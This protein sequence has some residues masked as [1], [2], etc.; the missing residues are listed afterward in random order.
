MRARPEEELEGI[1]VMRAVTRPLSEVAEP[2]FL[3]RQA[4]GDAYDSVTG[5]MPGDGRV[6]SHGHPIRVVV[7]TEQV[8]EQ[9]TG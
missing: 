5:V 3:V 1:D 7:G 8:T 4:G 6:K 2:S 9:V